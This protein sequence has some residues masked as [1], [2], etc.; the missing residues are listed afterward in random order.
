[1]KKQHPFNMVEIL[2]ALGVV[3]IG[4][5]SVMVL[6]PVGA[7]AS[8]DSIMEEYAASTAEQMLNMINF[9]L[10]MYGLDTT[11][12]KYSNTV[13][14]D[15]YIGTTAGLNGEL[16]TGSSGR[17]DDSDIEDMDAKLDLSEASEWSSGTNA[18]LGGSALQGSIFSHTP[19][20]SSSSSNT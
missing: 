14:W 8:R 2:L 5:C 20:G 10:H 13:Y 3:A 6:F 16:T 17:P 18:L 4:I 11:T 15:K 12:G 1:M 9:K 19:T 7:N